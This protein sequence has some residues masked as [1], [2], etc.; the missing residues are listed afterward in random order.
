MGLTNLS[1]HPRAAAA[2]RIINRKSANRRRP[3]L[4]FFYSA[5]LH[6]RGGTRAAIVRT[7]ALIRRTFIVS[8]RINDS[9][10]CPRL[11]DRSVVNICDYFVDFA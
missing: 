3:V 8:L 2:I 7:I 6:C 11:S 4:Q 5:R 1:K 10:Q 9:E